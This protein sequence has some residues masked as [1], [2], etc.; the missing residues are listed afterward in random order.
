MQATD[1]DTISVGALSVCFLVE[2]A[3][4]NGSAS[5][6]ECYVRTNSRM[7]A[8]HRHDGFGETIYGLEGTSTW[9]NRNAAS[10]SS[11]TP[12]LSPTRSRDCG[13]CGP[14][15]AAGS[16]PAAPASRLVVRDWGS[17][18]GARPTSEFDRALVN[19]RST[20]CAGEGLSRARASRPQAC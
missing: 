10:G 4:A 12:S 19:M 20:A 9:T 8:P 14:E 2:A 16:R 6:F 5:V 15:A 17:V 13:F 7:P 3:D 11:L 1:H 18:A